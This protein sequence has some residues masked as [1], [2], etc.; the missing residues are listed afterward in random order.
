MGFIDNFL[1]FVELYFRVLGL[2]DGIFKLDEGLWF[3]FSNSVVVQFVLLLI[4]FVY[5]KGFVR[6]RI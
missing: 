6:W 5:C 2:K 1:G 3:L 4:K